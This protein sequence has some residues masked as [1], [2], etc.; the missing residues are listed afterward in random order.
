MGN[1]MSSGWQGDL[2]KR[3]VHRDVSFDPDGGELQFLFL[4]H[5]RAKPLGGKTIEK[6]VEELPKP[7]RSSFLKTWLRSILDLLFMSARPET[8]F[9]LGIEGKTEPIF[10]IFR[11]VGPSNMVFHPSK[12][13]MVH[14][15]LTGEERYGL[16]RHVIAGAHSEAAKPDCRIIRFACRPP[17]IRDYHDGFYM[18]VRL[19][20]R[21]H[22]E[23]PTDPRYLDIDIDPDIRFPGGSVV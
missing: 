12:A 14:K 11:I 9:D 23:R 5:D 2:P 19:A 16:L 6:I 7:V 21:A 10:V 15:E 13:A 4:N 20:Q 8:P 1:D 17:N 18:R 3:Y 22:P